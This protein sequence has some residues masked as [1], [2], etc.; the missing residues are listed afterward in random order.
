[1]GLAGDLPISE[2]HDAHRVRRPPVAGEDI[3]IDPE[4]GRAEYPPHR[5]AFLFGWALRDA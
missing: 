4:I 1:L 3:F 2:L 5:E